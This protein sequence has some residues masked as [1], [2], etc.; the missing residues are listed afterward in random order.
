MY[1]YLYMYKNLYM[2]LYMYLNMHMYIYM[3]MDTY[4]YAEYE[5]LLSLPHCSLMNGFCLSSENY[6]PSQVE[7]EVLCKQGKH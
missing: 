4:M 3:D 5:N 1:M 7:G 6:Q 2:Y